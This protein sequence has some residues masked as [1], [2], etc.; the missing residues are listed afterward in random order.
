MQFS[1]VAVV[2]YDVVAQAAYVKSNYRHA[3]RHRFHTRLPQCFFQGWNYENVGC[4][5]H[6]RQTLLVVY[7]TEHFDI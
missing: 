7:K 2:G 3:T 1:K 4:G 6:L 5:I